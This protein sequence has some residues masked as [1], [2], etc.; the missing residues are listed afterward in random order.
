[1]GPLHSKKK[2]GL[3]FDVHGNVPPSLLKTLD[4]L[5][6]DTQ[7]L[8]H[9]RLRLPQLVSNLGELLLVH[10]KSPLRFF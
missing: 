10:P 2:Q 7:Q 8:R 4:G 5:T 9:F 1:M 3:P 6:G